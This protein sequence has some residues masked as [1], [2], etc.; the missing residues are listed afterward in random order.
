MTVRVSSVGTARDRIPVGG[1]RF[2]AFVQIGPG[3]YPASYTPCTGQFLGLKRP[4]C[5]ANHPLPSRAGAEKR[6]YLFSALCASWHVTGCTLTYRVDSVGTV[7]PISAWLDLEDSR[8]LRL[9][10]F[11]QNRHM[12]MTKLT[13]LRTSRLFP[14]R[15]NCWHLFLL[16]TESTSS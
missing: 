10:E 1:S 15:K 4:K 6:V 11:P 13:A 9:P 14:P 12:K 3:S 7:I 5:V 16:E 2:S 8:R